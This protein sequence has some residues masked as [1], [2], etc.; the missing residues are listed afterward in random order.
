L[1]SDK[2]D[3]VDTTCSQLVLANDLNVEKYYAGLALNKELKVVLLALIPCLFYM[4][5][6]PRSNANFSDGYFKD[7]LVIL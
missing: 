1:V 7:L 6:F 2:G 4:E 5:F 3:L